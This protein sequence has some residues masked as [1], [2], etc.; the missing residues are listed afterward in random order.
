[1]FLFLHMYSFLLFLKSL[2]EH[3]WYTQRHSEAKNLRLTWAAG[4]A[5]WIFF[6][7]PRARAGTVFRDRMNA[8]GKW[9]SG[10]L[11]NLSHLCEKQGQQTEFELFSIVKKAKPTKQNKNRNH[12]GR[13]DILR[14]SESDIR[15]VRLGIDNARQ[16]KKRI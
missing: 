13:T 12:T 14:L 16:Q 2:S 1:M 15:V 6:K 8:R 10:R 11:G 3:Q 9:V 4:N 7:H 5:C